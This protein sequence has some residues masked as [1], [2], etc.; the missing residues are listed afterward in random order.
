[1]K[2]NSD[3]VI[4]DAIEWDV[5]NW[6]NT[7]FF[8]SEAMR[9]FKPHNSRVLCL[10]ER[11][12]GLSLWFAL[13]GFTVVCSDFHG[14][15]EA[16]KLLH[17]QYQ[18]TELIEYANV[19]IFD[20]PYQNDSFDIVACK[21]VIGG[22]KLDYKDKRTRTLYNQK[23]AVN[24]VKRVLKPEGIFVGA[25]NMKGSIVHQTLRKLLKGNKIG[26]R[27]LSLDDITWIF[28]DYSERNF[29]FYGFLGT[30]FGDF[31]YVSGFFD[32]WLS[33]FLPKKWLYISFFIARK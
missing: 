9:E 25:E 33:K 2:W 22:L 6:A 13:Q 29:K 4:K 31:S 26:W 21:S 28:S 12:G 32:R 8:W 5:I 17:K 10:G 16:A 11:N 27:H 19:N 18:V 24:E 15:S 1:M 3:Q 7:L 23:L 14:P 20:I 30:Y